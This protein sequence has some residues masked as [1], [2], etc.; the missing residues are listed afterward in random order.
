MKTSIRIAIATT[1][2]VIAITRFCANVCAAPLK[3][4]LDQQRLLSNGAENQK[5]PVSPEPFEFYLRVATCT[6]LVL[7]GGLLAGLT[8]GLMSLDEMNLQ[9][10]ATSGSSRQQEYAKRIQPIRK[11][12]H[13]LLVTL[14]LGNTVV[15][16]SLP[17]IMDSVFGGGGITAV[18]VSTALVVIFGEIVPQALCARYGLTIGAF[19]AYPV[20]ALQ[21]LLAPLA[22]P[23]ALLL[24]TILG[25]GHSAT[26]KKAQLKELVSLSDAA[27]GGNLSADEVTIIRGALDLSEKLVVDVMTDLRNVFMVDV[28]ARLDRRLLTEMLR[29]GHSRVPVYSGRREDIVGV[30]LIK[31]LILLDPDDAV[32]VCDACIAPAPLVTPDT[33]L[34]DILNA[35]QEGGSHMAVV[36]GPPIL[37]P[38]VSTVDPRSC[39]GVG[40]RV[41]SL[42]SS[43]ATLAET[44]PLLF[45]GQKTAPNYILSD[46]VVDQDLLSYVP[47]GIITL[48]DVIEELIQEEIIDETDEF[49][50]IRRRIK[51]VRAT[52]NATNASHS[53]RQQPSRGLAFSAR[54]RQKAQQLHVCDD[55]LDVRPRSVPPSVLSELTDAMQYRLSASACHS[56]SSGA[57]AGA[58]NL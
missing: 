31:S 45:A 56:Y 20:R 14:L 37:S 35:F 44:T 1:G 50:D 27:H 58:V 19:F 28:Q 51:V 10:L 8:L 34:Y 3:A 17:I 39:L 53:L 29:R 33:S 15:N 41:D 13:W 43:E 54:R 21:Y 32:P 9:I 18:V 5:H 22:Y 42:S 12:G 40:I 6:I 52:T 11:N 49:I 38:S 25:A 48:E 47:I 30:L 2:T 57:N 16:E 23:V 7:V 46:P 55:M 36:M 4:D 24:D 26:Y